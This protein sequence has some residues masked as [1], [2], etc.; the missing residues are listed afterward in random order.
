MKPS[1]IH[2]DTCLT[3]SLPYKLKW[4]TFQ[5][6]IPI[7]NREN[8]KYCLSKWFYLPV[9]FTADGH[10]QKCTVM[11]DCELLK[12]NAYI[13]VKCCQNDLCNTLWSNCSFTFHTINIHS[14]LCFRS[15]WIMVTGLTGKISNKKKIKIWMKLT[16]CMFFLIITINLKIKIKEKASWKFL[17]ASENAVKK[18]KQKVQHNYH[19]P[20]N[21][22]QIYK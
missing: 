21:S 3:I 12:L 6:N 9:F 19:F 4:D 1:S 7:S 17:F 15:L 13:R 8:W 5:T 16:Y 11:A 2:I 22:T 20:A 14:H 18:T 10:Y